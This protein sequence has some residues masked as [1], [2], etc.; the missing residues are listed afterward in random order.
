[1]WRLSLV[2]ERESPGFFRQEGC[3]RQQAQG[4]CAASCLP[5]NSTCVLAVFVCAHSY[6]VRLRL[7]PIQAAL[8]VTCCHIRVHQLYVGTFGKY[9]TN[10]VGWCPDDQIRCRC[11]MHTIRGSQPALSDAR[12]HAFSFMLY[13]IYSVGL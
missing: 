10:I 8:F 7:L 9:W 1:M 5:A 4:E 3:A 11:L 6:C 12:H 2:F 13:E